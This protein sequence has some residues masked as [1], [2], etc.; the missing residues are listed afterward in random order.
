MILALMLA[1][2]GG[3][4]NVHFAVYPAEVRL[5]GALD[6][7]RI[8][9]VANDYDGLYGKFWAHLGGEIT[10]D[11]SILFED[12]SSIKLVCSQAA[13]L[14]CTASHGA[15]ML[16][17]VTF[18]DIPK[19]DNHGSNSHLAPNVCFGNDTFFLKIQIA[20]KSHIYS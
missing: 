15:S 10:T 8:V 7:Q 17:S 1:L 9:V 18:R 2:G 12:P 19:I 3:D 14:S 4:S 6:S 5:D 20:L 11:A 13:S 16:V